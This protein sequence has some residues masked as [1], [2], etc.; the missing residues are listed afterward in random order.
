M[1]NYLIRTVNIQIKSFLIIKSN[2]DTYECMFDL[3]ENP[4]RYNEILN[5]GTYEC[6]FN[7]FIRTVN[8]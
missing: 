5:S 4:C 2:S 8:I 3:I 7:Y 1:F 6:M